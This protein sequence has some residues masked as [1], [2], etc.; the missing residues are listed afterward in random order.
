LNSF[1]KNNNYRATKSK[2]FNAFV[3]LFLVSH[4]TLTYES[5]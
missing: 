5:P 3:N 1:Q 2:V 4:K